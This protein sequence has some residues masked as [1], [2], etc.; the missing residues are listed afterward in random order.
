MSLF[1]LGFLPLQLNPA[2]IPFNVL[3]AS[4]PCTALKWSRQPIE[5]KIVLP[6][7]V[8]YILGHTT[9]KVPSTVAQPTGMALA[10][11]TGMVMPAIMPTCV[12]A[13]ETFHPTALEVT[14]M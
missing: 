8:A 6:F 1:L 2:R 11:P 10:Q 4:S 3:P 5:Y 9:A 13:L 12:S 14:S 7:F